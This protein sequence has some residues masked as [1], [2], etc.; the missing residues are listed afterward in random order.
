MMA[1]T[2]IKI[3]SD[4]KN[5]KD[6][7]SFI[8]KVTSENGFSK[9]ETDGIVLAVDEA[10]TNIIRHSYSGDNTKDII[11]STEAYQD[12][13]LITLQD[14][15]EK[16]DLHRVENP[17]PEKL[18]KGRYGVVFIKK[19]MDKVEYDL[20]PEKGTILKLVKYRK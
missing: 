16:P 15:G 11:I 9:Q 19:L 12:K 14:F 20:S 13:L 18:R 4:T 7:R 10:C 6:I 8:R 2:T 17:P 1:T 5:L 3:K